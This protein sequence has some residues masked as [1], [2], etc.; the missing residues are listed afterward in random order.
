MDRRDWQRLSLTRQREASVLLDAGEYAGA[1]YLCGYA[2]EC[3]LKACVV[4]AIPPRTMPERHIVNDFYT[5]NLDKLLALTDLRP[6]LVADAGR[7][8][9]WQTVKDWSEQSRYR[10][11]TTAVQ[12]RDLYRACTEPKIGVLPWLRKSW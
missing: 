1:Y 5:H 2:V 9:N 4:K 11:D 7:R 12:A 10:A 3:A 6:G 8:V